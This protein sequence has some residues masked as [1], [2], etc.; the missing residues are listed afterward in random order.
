MKLIFILCTIL[1]TS[2]S[3]G[4]TKCDSSFFDKAI[5]FQENN[6]LD[7]AIDLYNKQIKLC[8]DFSEAYI[9]RAV[10]YFNS[11]QIEKGKQ[12]FNDAILHTKDKPK[13]L[14]QIA[15]F[16]FAGKFYDTA[17]VSYKNILTIDSN[18]SDAY[19]KMGRCK[20]LK[21]LQ[22]LKA[23]HQDYDYSQDKA[24]I[25]YLKNEIL[26]YYD[27]AIFLDSIQNYEK[28]KK[29]SEMEAFQDLNTNYEYYYFRAVVKQNF[30]DFNGALQDYE[31]SLLIHATIN[32][33]YWVAY[34]ARKVGENEKACEY[35]Q[36][37]AHTMSINRDEQYNPIQK[38]EIADKFCKELNIKK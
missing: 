2:L 20:W 34:T 23:A 25:S 32:T 28:Y 27:K 1:I 22:E 14:A 31:A 4:Q 37:W 38:V 18:Y 16:Y 8:P 13:T 11:N 30:N 9:N 7:K 5:D 6:K 24:F 3:N 10:C 33:Y 21:R 17:F 15:G 35:I 36:R 19:F 29:R 12:S 26:G